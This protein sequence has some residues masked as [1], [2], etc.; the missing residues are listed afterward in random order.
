M[1]GGLC[2]VII[3]ELGMES[4]FVLAENPQRL[5]SLLFYKVNRYIISLE[6]I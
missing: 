1:T 6:G 2:V 3:P 5:N 4:E